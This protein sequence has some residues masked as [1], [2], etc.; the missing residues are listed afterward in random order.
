MISEV[1]SDLMNVTAYNKISDLL[2]VG[3]TKK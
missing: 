1:D 3:D 2:C